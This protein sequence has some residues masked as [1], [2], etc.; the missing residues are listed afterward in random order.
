MKGKVAWF[1]GLSGAGKTTISERAADLLRERGQNV[2]VLDGDVVRATFH[3]HLGFSPED[4]RENNRLIAQLCQESLEDYDII[5]VPIMSPFRDSREAARK[6]LGTAFNE[7]YVYVS[8]DEAKRRDP[9]GY[10]RKAEQGSFTGMIGVAEQVPYE[11]P[12]SADLTLNT[13]TRDSETCARLLAE[14]LQRNSES[15]G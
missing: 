2:L 6:S 15:G 10:Y 9:K 11:P 13:E 7:I 3:R 5:L 1:T 8:L 12:D 4:I 14:Y